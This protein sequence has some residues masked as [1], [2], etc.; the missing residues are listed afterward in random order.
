MKREN[1]KGAGEPVRRYLMSLVSQGG[2]TPVKIPAERELAEM[3]GLSRGTGAAQ[4][5]ISRNPI[6]LCGCPD[7]KAHL[8][9]RVPH[10]W[11]WHP[12]AS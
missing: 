10:A 11:L 1:M 2:K 12:S 6:F 3:L 4:L 5:P 7:A 8:R 9:I